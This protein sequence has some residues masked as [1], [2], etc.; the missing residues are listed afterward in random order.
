MSRWS[1]HLEKDAFVVKDGYVAK[2]VPNAKA[3]E[4]GFGEVGKEVGSFPTRFAAGS[5]VAELKGAELHKNKVAAAKEL[6]G[7]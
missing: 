2:T 7:V 3:G 5:K 4:P 6:L 1:I